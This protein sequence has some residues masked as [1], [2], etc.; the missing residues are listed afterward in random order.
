MFDE[1]FIVLAERML[2]RRVVGR[3]AC[4]QGMREGGFK[5]K[6]KVCTG[7]TCLKDDL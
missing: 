2:E 3:M 5:L 1:I 4:H 7:A 6:C